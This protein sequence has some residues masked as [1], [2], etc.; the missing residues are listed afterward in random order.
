MPG[1]H[2]SECTQ[3]TL[4]MM[5]GCRGAGPP[6]AMHPVMPS[7]MGVTGFHQG[8]GPGEMGKLSQ[9]PQWGFSLTSLLQTIAYFAPLFLGCW[10]QAGGQHHLVLP[11]AG[12]HPA[13]KAGAG[14]PSR[15]PASWALLYIP[16]K[17]GQSLSLFILGAVRLWLLTRRLWPRGGRAWGGHGWRRDG[18]VAEPKRGQWLR[19]W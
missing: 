11:A 15:F 12:N 8:K 19:S 5:G 4:T 16:E 3:L 10:W 1:L 6:P 13:G 2:L 18:D 17:G 9:T 14:N 7:P